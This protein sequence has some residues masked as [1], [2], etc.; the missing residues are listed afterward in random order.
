MKTINEGSVTKILNQFSSDRFSP[1]V[2]A[3]VQRWLLDEAYAEEKEK[4]LYEFWQ[5]VRSEIDD[6]VYRSLGVAKKRLGFLTKKRSL[7]STSKWLRVAAVILP[8]SI[9]AMVFYFNRG[10][11]TPLVEHRVPFGTFL[12]K[13]LP[14]GSS[15][16]LNSG[17]VIRFSEEFKGRERRVVLNGEASFEVEKNRSKPFVIETPH[18]L[19]KVLGTRLNVKAY[20][21]EEKSII[22]LSSGS[23]R[24]E[25]S[26]GRD[27]LLE[28]G[29]RLVYNNQSGEVSLESVNAEE[30]FGWQGQLV[31]EDVR[32]EEIFR[33]IE[34]QHNVVITLG[35]DVAVSER[36]SIKFVRGETAEEIMEVL[37]HLV[38]G[39]TYEIKRL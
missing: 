22:T 36:Y 3:D 11:N 7:L 13:D 17:S 9:I 39:F 5:L 6:T 24:V 27:F 2:E 23:A 1:E 32:L 29:R 8:L 21:E 19:V 16:C 33:A 15:V 30:D 37:G 31:F 25:A 35:E 10:T 34:R 28:P 38:G 14:D 4:A 20:P 26:G 12:E 18:L